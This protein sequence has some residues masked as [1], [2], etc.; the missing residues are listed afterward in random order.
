MPMTNITYKLKRGT[1]SA[2]KQLNPVLQAGE[3]IV[4]FCSNGQIQLKIGDGQTPY[5]DLALSTQI[6]DDVSIQ[7]KDNKIALVG[8]ESAADLTVPF[9]VTEDLLQWVSLDFISSNTKLNYNSN[10]GEL[11]L[12]SL[13]GKIISSL[14][15]AEFAVAG[16]IEDVGYDAGNNT[17]IFIWNTT[18]GTKTS[19][20]P[21]NNMLSPYTEG[22]GITINDNVIS[23]KVNPDTE[24]YL[25]I[26]E[27]GIG[28]KGIQ[29]ALDSVVVQCVGQLD[30]IKVDISGLKSQQSATTS[31][32]TGLSSSVSELSKD[33]SALDNTVNTT[34]NTKLTEFQDEITSDINSLASDLDSISATVNSHGIE[35]TTVYDKIT[36]LESTIGNTVN[37]DIS[38]SISS[39]NDH[40]DEIDDSLDTITDTIQK[41]KNQDLQGMI[42]TSLTDYVK[43]SDIDDAIAEAAKDL[44]INL[45]RIDGGRITDVTI[46][47]SQV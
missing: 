30:S 14:D 15:A 17:L 21:L 9:K 23:I 37:T 20:I 32:L 45:D 6:P 13:N 7:F 12:C 41:L 2:L 33:I 40:L 42:N 36:E 34:I 31:Q 29:E 27:S 1:D 35:F 38:E 47:E 28:I 3:P 25:F 10:T 19:T 44:N 8:F 43:F 18:N 22:S 46:N 4:V 5:N 11:Q 26:N 39:I 16:L 24:N